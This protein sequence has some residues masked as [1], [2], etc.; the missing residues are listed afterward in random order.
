MPSV[1]STAWAAFCQYCEKAS[2]SLSCKAS[3]LAQAWQQLL[4]AQRSAV[5]CFPAA[6]WRRVKVRA[7]TAWALSASSW[8]EAGI[9]ESTT[10]VRY[11]ESGRDWMSLPVSRE[12]DVSSS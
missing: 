1:S 6:T 5:S 10:P 7:A 8:K 4:S 2:P 11:S 12:M 9:S 3:R